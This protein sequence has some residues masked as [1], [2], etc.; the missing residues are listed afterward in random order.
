[1]REAIVYKKFLKDL[2]AVFSIL[3]IIGLVFVA[4]F[5][6]QIAPDST[7][8]ANQMHLSIHSKPPGFKVEMLM[9]QAENISSSSKS[10]LS[11]EVNGNTEIPIQDYRLQPD[12]VEIQPYGSPSNYYEF[13]DA[14]KLQSPLSDSTFKKQYLEEKKYE[15]ISATDIDNN[16]LNK[17][18]TYDLIK[19]L[20]FDNYVPSV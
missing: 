16:E 19:K 6:Y 2:W 8:N 4:V 15:E 17:L 13:I 9:L 20:L 14:S 12:G 18:C 3:Y 7:S 11:G 5:A 10:F 1:M